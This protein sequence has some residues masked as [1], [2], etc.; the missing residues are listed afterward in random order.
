MSNRTV[1]VGLLGCG[2]VGS[3]TCRL[4]AARR[5][6]IAL[7]T[8]CDVEISRVAVRNL[9]KDRDVDVPHELFTNDPHLIVKDPEIDIV[10]EVIG[11][12]E[13]ARTL[14]LEAVEAGKH[15]VTAN[16][17]LISSLGSELFE[18]AAAK[19]VDLLFEASV[20]GGIPLIRPL[21]ESLAGEKVRSIMGIV[22]GTTNYV[23][24]RMSEDGMS[25]A[26]AVAEAQELGYAERDPTA[27]V[28]GYDAAAKTAILASIAFDSWV[29]SGDV[30]REGI[31]G[32]T[33]TD[34]AI[35]KRLG[36]VIK[37]LA[38]ARLDDGEI[39]VRV[40]PSMIPATHPLA[41]VRE[42]FNAVFVEGD[43]V[44]ELMFYGQG[45]GGGP[46][47]TSVVGDIV[48]VARNLRDGGRA[49]RSESRLSIPIRAFDDIR[50]QYYLLLEV[51]DEPGVLAQI[52]AEFGEHDVSIASV[53]QEGHG[54]QAYLVIV[55]HL[56]REQDL[57]ATL[58]ALRGLSA[59]SDVASV[60]RVEAEEA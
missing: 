12:I 45:A 48:E 54:D 51:A 60:L 13:P 33:E 22:N 58:H 5:D 49:A 39:E 30:Y 56:A 47:A 1:R 27:D 31:S 6:E 24:T 42:S 18:A 40:H 38:V 55:T 11:G 50:T 32:I 46:T 36:Y 26:N 53:W 34:I 14:I 29:S 57:Q 21:N 17:E 8:G 44:G 41:N 35:A 37:L 28:E 10:V 25:L 16:K 7:R 19:G 43:A 4:I 23:L 2:I 20:G 52:A 3:A 59:V 15:V 9:S